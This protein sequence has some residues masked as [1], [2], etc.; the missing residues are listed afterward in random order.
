VT[1]V[2]QNKLKTTMIWHQKLEASG[3]TTGSVTTT[4]WTQTSV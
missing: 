1:Y 3:I 2:Y 4:R